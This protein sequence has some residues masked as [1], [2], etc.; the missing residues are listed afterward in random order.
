MNEAVQF[1]DKFVPNI[2]GECDNCGTSPTVS[3]EKN[4]KLVYQGSLCGPCTW[5]REDMADPENWN[6]G[7]EPPRRRVRA[8]Q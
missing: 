6:T 8:G 3:A 2:A 1:V 4:G 7:D 5:G